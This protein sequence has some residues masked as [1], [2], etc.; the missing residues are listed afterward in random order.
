MLPR[1][2]RIA[3]ACH[4]RMRRFSFFIFLLLFF[5]F[6][7][8][9]HITIIPVYVGLFL[10]VRSRLWRSM[11]GCVCAYSTL[12]VFRSQCVWGLSSNRSLYSFVWTA[13]QKMYP[14][15]RF[16]S[17]HETGAE[18]EACIRAYSVGHNL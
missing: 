15:L 2:A 3:I 18:S 11:D 8:S 17:F 13:Q 10:F 9:M 1:F 5:A 14:S 6:F 4:L 12:Q 16:D 7:S